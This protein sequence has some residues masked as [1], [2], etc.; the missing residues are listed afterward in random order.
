MNG[1]WYIGTVVGHQLAWVRNCSPGARVARW[2]GELGTGWECRHGYSP[3]S[4]AT[5][6]TMRVQALPGNP[7]RVSTSEHNI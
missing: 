3:D 2:P 7:E 6:H 1:T 5:D 4:W